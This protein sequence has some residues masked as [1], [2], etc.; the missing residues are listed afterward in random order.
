[1]YISLM[2]KALSAYSDEHI[3]RYFNEVKTN[4]LT[5]H[6]FPR[7]TANIGILIAHGKRLDLLP[8]FIEMMEFCCKSIP[9]VKAANDFSVREIVCCLLEIEQSG[10]IPKKETER[11][12]DYLASIEPTSCYNKYAKA[13]TDSVRNWALFTAVSEYFRQDAGLCDSTEFI[14]LQLEQQLQWLDE[15]GM[16]CDNSK[17]ETMQPIMYDLA[18]RALFAML[19]ERGYCGKYRERIDESLKKAAMLTLDMQSPKGE[20]AFGGRSNQFVHNEPWVSAVFEYEAKRYAKEG[21]FPLASR[22]K[23][24]SARALEVTEE[25]LN[26][27]PIRHIK[28]RFPKE[29]KYGCENYAYFDKYMIT[30]ASNLYGAY[31]I[32]D[33]T[34]PFARESDRDPC[35]ARTS[36]AFH[37]LF[38]KAAG[39]GLEFDLNADPHYDANGLGRIHYKDAPS[40]ICM[41][42]P[43]PAEP[44]YTVDIESNM[45]LSFC[46]AIKDKGSWILGANPGCVYEVIDSR[47]NENGVTVELECRYE[48]GKMLKETYSVCAEGVTVTVKGSGTVGFA[49]PVLDFDGEK[50]TKISVSEKE[51]SIAYEGW[52]ALYITDGKIE[53]LNRITANRSGHYRAFLASGNRE[54]K[55]KIEIKK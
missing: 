55:I 9:N 1:M 33:E 50:Q 6:G 14:E 43:C 49:L 52:R 40:A 4:G 46:S 5:E 47:K 10:V 12:R 20:M 54:L 38:A 2:E 27:T 35:V 22:F 26:K 36:A 28:N 11:W 7:L 31:L 48:N 39:Y 8:L 21:N 25:W 29:T 19:L 23:A 30:A 42:L 34:I 13:P 24:A 41:S 18:P 32:C 3:L 37:K 16:Y 17:A 45:A 15:N 44:N 51:I 53:N